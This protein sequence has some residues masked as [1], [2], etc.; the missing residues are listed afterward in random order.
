[1]PH[2]T[3]CTEMPRGEDEITQ[4]LR[5]K[6]KSTRFTYADQTVALGH[7]QGK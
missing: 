1:M 3:V 4:E 6:V 5:E 7:H 2:N